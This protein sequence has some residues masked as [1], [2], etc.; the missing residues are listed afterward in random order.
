MLMLAICLLAPIAISPLIVIANRQLCAF[1]VTEGASLFVGL[2]MHRE[3]ALTLA[4]PM[5]IANT[6]IFIFA[7]WAALGLS[8][9]QLSSFALATPF[10]VA[11]ALSLL[12]TWVLIRE[13]LRLHNGKACLVSLITFAGGNLPLLIIMPLLVMAVPDLAA[14]SDFS[15][16]N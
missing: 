9:L 7:W 5:S 12:V 8:A 4:I 15:A 11:L 14:I 13:R 6:V 3:W 2:E 10:I 1:F 16:Q